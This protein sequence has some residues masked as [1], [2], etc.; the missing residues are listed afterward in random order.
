MSHDDSGDDNDNDE[1]NHQYHCL[2]GLLTQIPA[3]SLLLFL[4]MVVG[5]IQ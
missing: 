1:G 5:W 3:L 2:Q 4:L